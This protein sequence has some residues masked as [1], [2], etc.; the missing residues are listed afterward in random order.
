MRPQSRARRGSRKPRTMTLSRLAA[1]Y[2]TLAAPA[3]VPAPSL[4]RTGQVLILSF[5]ISF[6][7]CHPS[8]MI[9]AP[10][11][12]LHACG[13]SD[14]GNARFQNR[15]LIAFRNSQENSL[16]K[17]TLFAAVN[18]FFAKI[19]CGGDLGF[20]GKFRMLILHRLTSAWLDLLTHGG[21]LQVRLSVSI[22][23][24]DFSSGLRAF[25]RARDRR[26][27]GPD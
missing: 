18:D 23:P 2:A 3:F 16:A 24:R 5:K 15:V 20:G 10:F 9:A 11:R 25:Y 4:D 7:M 27:E 6:R 12:F 17:I 21:R 8:G 26:F 14:G 19:P 1:R 13:K 22:S